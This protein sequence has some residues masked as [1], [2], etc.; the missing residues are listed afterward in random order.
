MGQGLALPGILHFLAMHVPVSERARSVA[1]VMSGNQ[2]GIITAFATTPLIIEGS[3]WSRPF[4]LFGWSGIAFCLIW[5]VA[6]YW[7]G[8]GN[9][10]EINAGPGTIQMR[11]LLGSENSLN[12]SSKKASTVLVAICKSQSAWALAG[13]IF[14]PKVGYPHVVDPGCAFFYDWSNFTIMNY[15]P[16]YYKDLGLKKTNPPSLFRSLSL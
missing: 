5:V 13:A 11:R 9:G 6:T 4:F 2:L 8:Q 16:S 12:A 3:D 14:S 15:M 1:L 7:V 10:G